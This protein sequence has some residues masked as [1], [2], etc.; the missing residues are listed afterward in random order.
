MT[1]DD[2]RNLPGFASGES[3][4]KSI[5]HVNVGSGLPIEEEITLALQRAIAGGCT[6]ELVIHVGNH[7]L[8]VLHDSWCPRL[9]RIG[10]N[11]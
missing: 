2:G 6:C 1:W 9:R 8:E 7:G 10:S 3:W 11:Q 4:A 5:S